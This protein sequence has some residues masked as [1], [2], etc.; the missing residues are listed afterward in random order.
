MR[1]NT[2]TGASLAALTI[3][4]AMA[5]SASGQIGFAPRIDLS[6]FQRPAGVAA[7]D[8]TGDGN[9]DLAV[10]VDGPDRVLIQAGDGAGGFVAGPATLLG[11]GVGADALEAHDID[12]DGDMDMAVSIDSFLDIYRNDAGV[13]ALAGRLPVGSV[14]PSAVYVGN[15]APGG[16]G[17][18]LMTVNGDGG[19]VSV[20]ENL[21][22]MAFG[23]AMVL[24]SGANP[25]FAAVADLDGSGSDDIAV[26]NQ[27]SNTTS[28]FLNTAVVA[29][30]PADFD[31]DGVLSLFDF[32]AFQSAFD[33]GE[34][35]A[36]LDGDGQFTLF[37]FLAYQNLFVAGC[38]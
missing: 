1:T 34:P 3:T 30:C 20:F 18:D 25:S 31:G 15:F 36:D 29:P 24:P 23:P 5:A 2:K 9:M 6:T 37:D 32:L 16:A 38:P 11:S 10:V 26:T 22:G 13:M 35:R 8:F 21:G 4:G 12:G 33:S 28:V 7:G 19:S 14:D 27:D 17:P